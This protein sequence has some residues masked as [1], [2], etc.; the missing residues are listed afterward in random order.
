MN[1]EPVSKLLVLDDG[2]SHARRIKQFCD[3]NHLVPLKVRK[4]SVMSVLRT[5]IDLGGILYSENYEDSPEETAR[6]ALEIHAARPELPIII[7]R[8]RQAT[9][10]GLPDA[11]QHAYCAAYV[12][13][14]MSALRKVIDE[15]IFC[16][17][18][19]NALLRG[20]AEITEAVLAGQFKGLKVA[21]DTPYIV[22]DRVI[23]GELFS[24]IQLESSW[25]RGYMMLQTEEDPLLELIGRDAPQNLGATFRSVNDLLSEITN[26]IWGSFKNRYI[27]DDKAAATG[28]IQ[29]PLVVNHKHKY[30][31]FGTENPQLCFRFTLTDE[32]T[33]RSSTLYERFI[34]NL[35]WSPED[36][37]EIAPDTAELVDSGELELF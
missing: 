6:V 23:F 26:L 1:D 18:Y 19:P 27:G 36:F 14:D 24:L 20:I 25:C 15:Y 28:R 21:M 3:E 35:N 13:S 34:F 9:L 11:S 22:H 2:P 8:E 4:G 12:A 10:A 33:G 17:M 16:L 32:G 5:N 29:I 7:R 30:I 37:K 31:S